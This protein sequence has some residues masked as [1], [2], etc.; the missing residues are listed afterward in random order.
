MDGEDY[1]RFISMVRQM[2]ESQITYFKTRG[3]LDDCKKIE[4]AVDGWLKE[5]ADARSQQSKLF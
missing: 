1:D 3:G 4:R 5:Y 2:R